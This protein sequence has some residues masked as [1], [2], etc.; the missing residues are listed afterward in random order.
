MAEAPLADWHRMV[1]VNIKGFLSVIHACLPHL[2]ASKGHIVNSRQS[3]PQC[4]PQLVVYAGTKHFV[5]V[6]S[7]GLRLELRDK[8][9]VTNIS[10]GA[11]ETEFIDHITHPTVKAQYE[12]AFQDV[13]KAADI[14]K[15]I[16]DAMDTD[17]R[18]VISELI[19][20]ANK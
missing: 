8:V 9:R 3:C 7:Q 19:V 20:R 11:V 17:P 1:D 5:K 4:V 18:M 14:G 15:A 10:P 16:A 13:L 2:L 12:K 6:I